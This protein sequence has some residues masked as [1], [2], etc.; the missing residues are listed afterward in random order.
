MIFVPDQAENTNNLCLL[1]QVPGPHKQLRPIIRFRL[2][3]WWWTIPVCALLSLQLLQ[4]RGEMVAGAALMFLC[5]CQAYLDQLVEK[6][7]DIVTRE[8][9]GKS[10]Q[11]KPETRWS[12]YS[13]DWPAGETAGHGDDHPAGGGGGGRGEGGEEENDIGDGAPAAWGESGLLRSAG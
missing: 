9:L 5:R 8:S 13:V 1:L 2:R 6:H 10:I 7:P 3:Y 4:V 11:V 12:D